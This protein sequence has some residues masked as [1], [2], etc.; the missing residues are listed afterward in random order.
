VIDFDSLPR[1]TVFKVSLPMHADFD[2]TV[3]PSRDL[4]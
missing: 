2:S 3:D 1:R 4:P